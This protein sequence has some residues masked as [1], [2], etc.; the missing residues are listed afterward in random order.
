MD[1]CVDQR[2]GQDTLRWL[3]RQT[4]GSSRQR[5]L[6]SVMISSTREEK[7]S[8]AGN[9]PGSPR[10]RPMCCRPKFFA[11]N[12]RTDSAVNQCPARSIA[13]ASS[14]CSLFRFQRISDSSTCSAAFCQTAWSNKESECPVEL[15]HTLVAHS[16][17]R[18]ARCK[19][20]SPDIFYMSWRHRIIELNLQLCALSVR[21]F[22]RAPTPIARIRRIIKAIFCFF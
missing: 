18:A 16:I 14:R 21:D 8:T 1:P 3:Q 19:E 13:L 17:S 4:Q 22:P 6:S 2:R 7:A 9:L 10:H 20:K 15:P 12:L 11:L 5:A